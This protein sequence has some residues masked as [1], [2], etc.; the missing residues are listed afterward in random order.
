MSPPGQ[1]LHVK[2]N[3]MSTN[4]LLEVVKFVRFFGMG[5]EESFV[6]RAG[7]RGM[8]TGAVHWYGVAEG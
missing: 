7:S 3:N 4:P 2:N 5:E 1:E 8:G 6:V